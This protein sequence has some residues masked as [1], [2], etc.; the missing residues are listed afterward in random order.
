MPPP[1]KTNKQKLKKQ[2]KNKQKRGGAPLLGLAK[3][4]Y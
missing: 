1:K 4:V 2:T 3:S